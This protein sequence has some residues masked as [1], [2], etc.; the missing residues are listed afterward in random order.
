MLQPQPL[1]D[2]YAGLKKLNALHS[3]ARELAGS[4]YPPPINVTFEDRA[5]AAGIHQPGCNLCGDCV[6][7]CNSGA[8]N[9]LLMNY[10]PDA[11]ANGA[12]VFTEV[13]VHHLSR[14]DERWVVHCELLDT[15]QDLFDAPPITIT[16]DV[17][18]LSAGALGSTEILL[19][20]RDHINLSDALGTRFTGNGDVLGFS[21]NGEELIDGMGWGIPTTTSSSPWDRASPASWICARA[22][23]TKAL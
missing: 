22:S 14:T 8:K 20:S 21:Y 11:V 18:V 7:G 5:N 10:L 17:V 4:F 2:S 12:K 9:T 13:S 15:G 16:A 23:S 19:R 1:P 3:S 6:S